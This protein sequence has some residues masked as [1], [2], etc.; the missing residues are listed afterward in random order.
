MALGQIAFLGSGETSRAGG[1]IFEMLA[2]ALPQ[3]LHIAVLETPAGFELN[4]HQVAGRVADF[5][6]VRLQNYT[7]V[8][9]VVPARK[10][11]TPFSPDEPGILKP[12]LYA[13][14][15]FMGPGSPTYAIRQ[16]QGS[17]AWDLVRAR[18]RKGAT[19]AFASSAT[20]AVGAWGLPVYEV[21]KVGQDIHSVPGLNLFQDFGAMVSFIPHWNNAEGGD[22]V[23]TSRCFVGRERFDI[24]CNSLPAENTTVGL[25]EHTGLLVDFESGA[26]EVS[27][28]SSVSL[29]HD[30]EAKVYPA[31][32]KFALSQLGTAA[33]PDPFEEGIS[34]RAWDLVKNAPELEE[35]QPSAEVLALVDQRQQARAGKHWAE[36]DRLREQIAALG[37][38]VQD[39]KDGQ[40][41]VRS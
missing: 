4:S 17:L 38:T 7:P 41:L 35:E 23:D 22:D 18:H 21:Y 20:I 13:N 11:G 34:S 33:I 37:W 32:A 25:D 9:D 14:L 1:T 24:W 36:S 6:R 15:I 10:R 28:V 19:L 26:C 12:L 27:G 16:L 3:P 8:I 39:T 31:G 30:C 5:L 2:R 40:K 29:V